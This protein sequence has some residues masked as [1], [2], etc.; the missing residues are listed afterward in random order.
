MESDMLS[1]IMASDIGASVIMASDIGASDMESDM[2]SV[3]FSVILAVDGAI[4]PDMDPEVSMD[5]PS[6]LS[7][8]ARP[9]AR[10]AQVAMA[11]NFF[12]GLLL[13]WG[14]N[15][16]RGSQGDRS[17]STGVLGCADNDGV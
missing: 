3:I 7:H 2:E 16:V 1:A 5:L 12:M 14:V 17:E 6:V 15:S 8:A 13:I 10:A 4:V 9:V 11:R